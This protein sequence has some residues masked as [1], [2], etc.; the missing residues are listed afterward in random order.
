MEVN[1]CTFIEENEN[2]DGAYFIEVNNAEED[3]QWYSGEIDECID[4]EYKE[5]AL[6]SGAYVSIGSHGVEEY[7]FKQKRYA[8]KAARIVANKIAFKIQEIVTIND[9]TSR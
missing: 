4:E 2:D 5:T 7:F 6:S 8:L 3:K 9:N 1:I